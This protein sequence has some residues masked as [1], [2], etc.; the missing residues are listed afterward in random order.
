MAHISQAATP[1]VLSLERDERWRLALRVAQSSEF[2][3]ATRLREF[4]LYVC[5]KTLTNRKDEVHEQLIAVEVFGRPTDYNPADDNI[6]RVEAR[7]LRRRLDIYFLTEGRG[8]QLRIRI[9]KGSYIPRFEPNY[10][11]G[12]SRD[13]SSPASREAANRPS[14]PSLLRGAGWLPP[15]RN[16][17]KSFK[18]PLSI[19]V[20][21]LLAMG[22]FVFLLGERRGTK[23]AI[24]RSSATMSSGSAAVTG[25]WWALFPSSRP[26]EIVVGD[27]SLVL[28]EDIS[29]K[30]F[31]L[32]DYLSGK[33]IEQLESPGIR[34]VVL[35]P[36]T[37]LADV[38][39]T[40]EI[41]Q[42]AMAQGKSIAIR[43]ARDLH[44]RDLENEDLIFL[45]TSYSD[46]WI[47]E[48]E[49]E[50]EFVLGVQDDS[51]RRLCFL[52][53][54]PQPG[55]RE[56]YCTGQVNGNRDEAYGVVT[57]LPNL[58]ERGNILILA[59]TTSQGTEAVGDF[60]AHL[61]SASEIRQY[62]ALA[63]G[64]PLPYFQLLFKTAV[65]GNA[66]GKR[67]LI[68]HRTLSPSRH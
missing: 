50:G 21:G 23:V 59:G 47:K 54:F 61:H 64:K 36:Y 6:V 12:T 52:D 60:M 67:E 48:F 43:Y 38:L 8:E 1:D 4:L 16:V 55:G 56:R 49:A 9:P 17:S 13:S 7:E 58:R 66:P 22:L 10:D 19:L 34:E 31:S 57:F 32:A 15:I 44:I 5:Q 51:G 3:K 40:S 18:A 62:L 41:Q 24:E 11:G 65:V 20:L 26:V 2:Q 30:V 33:Y 28:A 53:K 42:T 45:G 35:H 46:P 29:G 37:S 14:V 39:A 25:I 63:E 27:S 68:T